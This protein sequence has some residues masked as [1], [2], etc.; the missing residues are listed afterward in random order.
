[1]LIG[2][3]LTLLLKELYHR[4]RPDFLP[5]AYETSYSFPSGHAMNSLIFYTCLSFFVL[6]H[7]KNKQLRMIFFVLSGIL[8]FL[9]GISRIYLGVHYPSDVIGGYAAG[10]CWLTLVFSVAKIS[11]KN[12]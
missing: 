8:I 9:I 6:N 12:Q 5:L 2:L 7:V 4:V 3:G 11:K 1:M 10:F